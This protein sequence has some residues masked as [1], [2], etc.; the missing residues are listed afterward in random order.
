MLL[1][2]E[3][4]AV[5]EAVLGKDILLLHLGTDTPSVGSQDQDVHSDIVEL[6][7]AEGLVTPTPAVSVN[8]PLVDVTEANGPFACYPG[9]HL[10]RR[11]EGLRRLA[12][13]SARMEPV[14]LNRGDVM[15]RD[16]RMLHQGTANRTGIPR[17]VVVVAY[18][19][20]WYRHGGF[21]PMRVPPALR[22]T[23]PKRLAQMLRLHLEHDQRV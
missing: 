13:G 7:P 18:Q 1:H 8:F 12:E 4:L 15:L 14:L 21:E 6:F 11:E 19:R 9:S 2:P 20:S 23:L 5:V 10:L 3:I 16:P 17:P 22:A